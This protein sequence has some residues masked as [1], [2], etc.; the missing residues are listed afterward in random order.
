MASFA[1][2]YIPTTSAQV[3][4]NADQAS[5]TG[6]NFSSWYN[7]SQGSVYTESDCVVSAG[8][9]GSYRPFSLSN[10]SLFYQINQ[11]QVYEYYTGYAFNISINSTGKAATSIKNG[12]MAVVFNGGSASTSTGVFSGSVYNTLCIGSGPLTNANFLN[13][14]IRKLTYYPQALSSANLVALTS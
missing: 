6:T 10:N 5:M 1:T 13:G 3:T 14:H 8:L 4:R 12:A 9:A 7:Q 2:S 11:G